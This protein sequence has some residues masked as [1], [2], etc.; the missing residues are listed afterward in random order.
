[1]EPMDP[2]DPDAALMLAFQK[3]D[4]TAFDQILNKYSRPIVNFLYRIV[5]NRAEAEELA[6]EVFLRVYRA[7]QSYEP[8]APLGAWL[9]RIASNLGIRA[10]RRNRRAPFV[11]TEQGA[12]SSGAVSLVDRYPDPQPDPERLVASSETD[13]IVRNAIRALPEKERVALVLRRY[14]GLSYRDIAAVMECTEAA[15]KTYIHRG[16]LRVRHR[17]LPHIRKGEI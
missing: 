17:M 7:R 14:E 9:F 13:R 2:I 4:N 6:Q 12:D 15:V 16:K 8:R 5:N 10:A 11:E 1:M 3:G